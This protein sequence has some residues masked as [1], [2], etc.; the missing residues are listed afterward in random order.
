[1]AYVPMMVYGAQPFGPNPYNQWNNGNQYMPT[2]PSMPG[3]YP[4][5]HNPLWGQPAAFNPSWGQPAPPI[6]NQQGP[7]TANRA[8]Q[9]APPRQPPPG[10]V[11][12]EN[13]N[14][15]SS[16]NNGAGSLPK[17]PGTSQTAFETPENPVASEVPL[18]LE[19]AQR[20]KTLASTVASRLTLASR[21]TERSKTPMNTIASA[22]TQDST[23]TERPKTPTNT[24]VSRS[25]LASRP[26][27][28]PRTDIATVLPGGIQGSKPTKRPMTL[29]NTVASIPQ[30]SRLTVYPTTSSEELTSL[31][32]QDSTLTDCARSILKDRTKN[33]VI[34]H[35]RFTITSATS[36][37]S[38]RTVPSTTTSC[39]PVPKDNPAELLAWIANRK[40]A[41][42]ANEIQASS[43]SPRAFEDHELY[44]YKPKPAEVAKPEATLHTGPGE[45]PKQAARRND[46]IVHVTS[47]SP[48]SPIPSSPPSLDMHVKPREAPKQADLQDE[49]IDDDISPPS[50]IRSSL[51]PSNMEIDRSSLSNHHTPPRRFGSP[52]NGSVR[53]RV[54]SPLYNNR[55][56][57]TPSHFQPED[58]SQETALQKD[59]SA[60][61]RVQRQEPMQE[62]P[63]EPWGRRSTPKSAKGPKDYCDITPRA[64]DA[65]ML[66]TQDTSIMKQIT[67]QAEPVDDGVN[68]SESSFHRG[69]A[70]AVKLDR[71]SLRKRTV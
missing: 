51:P 63:L 1:M 3:P 61:K 21:P 26:T 50:S 25:P 55:K 44:L 27:E 64:A 46:P 20:P 33:L 7:Y 5:G 42:E 16:S 40:A 48:P 10:F 66:G 69:V 53:Q 30:E 39:G 9:R 6:P 47:D 60:A 28:R 24:V 56:R 58:E 23:T 68:S 4:A 19:V 29:T 11:S 45:A 37:S 49:P 18:G 54:V 57:M 36:P 34:S 43:A 52:I 67:S 2:M 14:A 59:L 22:V 31:A 41:K 15:A 70:D 71:R 62:E 17:K 8:R 38:S 65:M 35:Q 32:P 13:E 12:E